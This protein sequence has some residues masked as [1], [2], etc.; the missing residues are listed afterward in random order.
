LAGGAFHDF[1]HSGQNWMLA[2]DIIV[3]VSLVAAVWRRS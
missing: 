3:F 1:Q 2:A